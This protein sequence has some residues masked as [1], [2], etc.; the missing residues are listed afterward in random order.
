VKFRQR[1]HRD[2]SHGSSPL[3]DIVYCYQLT[4]IDL[5]MSITMEFCQG[6][7]DSVPPARA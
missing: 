5:T 7:Q 1:T 4:L 3:K 6:A 2:K